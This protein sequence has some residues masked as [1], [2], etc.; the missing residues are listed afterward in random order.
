MKVIVRSDPR[1]KIVMYFILA[2]LTAVG[3]LA[4]VAA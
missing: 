3:L 2:Q 4:L 1:M